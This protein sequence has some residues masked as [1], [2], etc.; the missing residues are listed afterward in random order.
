MAMAVTYATV[1]GRLVQESRG[2]G[3]T[4]YVADTLGS[5]I[6]TRDAGGSQTSAVEYWPYGEVRNS[7]GTNPS[8]WA[9]VGTLGYHVDTLARLYVRARILRTDLCRWMSR[10]PLWPDESAYGY[11]DAN[12]VSRTDPSGLACSS[13]DW[14][15]C[16]DRGYGGCIEHTVE[17]QIG[18]WCIVGHVHQCIGD[19]KGRDYRN[20]RALQAGCYAAVKFRPKGWD[21][22]R[23][24]HLCDQCY[25]KCK[26]AGI[27]GAIS[28]GCD[29]WNMTI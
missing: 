18:P 27:I 19:R 8:P 17:T 21:Y 14:Q 23:W 16:W 4:R 25:G 9:F 12:P 26:S 10:D 24:Y 20:C 3:V 22:R 7:S 11:A 5:L 15:E 28:T 6:Q 1:N 13:S 2:G 29:F